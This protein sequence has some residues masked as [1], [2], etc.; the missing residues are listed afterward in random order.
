M[1][2]SNLVASREKNPLWRHFRTYEAALWSLIKGDPRTRRRHILICTGR[3]GIGKTKVFELLCRQYHVHPALMSS[4]INPY[5]YVQQLY[6]YRNSPI[7]CLDDAGNMDTASSIGEFTKAAFGP[8]RTVRHNIKGTKKEPP[9]PEEF[10]VSAALVWL[11]NKDFDDEMNTRKNA[12]RPFAALLTRA[13]VLNMDLGVSDTDVFNYTLLLATQD[14]M[15]EKANNLITDKAKI[16]AINWYIEHRNQLKDIT[17]RTLDHIGW[18]FEQDH[19]RRTQNRPSRDVHEILHI[20]LMPEERQIERIPGFKRLTI[21]D[22]QWKEETPPRDPSGRFLSM[23][24]Q[25]TI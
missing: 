10:K 5:Q 23:V 20:L 13:N 16:N 18:E 22:G 6:R 4:D 12:R 19:R 3:G 17:P 15:F 25:P 9:P 8:T 2:Y 14:K 21:V 1:N 24:V 11:T 7:I